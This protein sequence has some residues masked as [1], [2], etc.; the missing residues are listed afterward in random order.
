MSRAI[1]RRMLFSFYNPKGSFQPAEILERHL[2]FSR[3]RLAATLS[4]RAM[5]LASLPPLTLYAD[6]FNT[7][8]FIILLEQALVVLPDE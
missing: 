4:S 8:P 2:S 3:Y 5:V 7:L 6:D 1:G